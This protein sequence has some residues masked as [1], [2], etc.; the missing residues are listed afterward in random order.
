MEAHSLL[1]NGLLRLLRDFP[2]SLWVVDADLRVQLALGADLEA[3]GDLVG[4]TLE[5]VL[6]PLGESAISAHRAALEG[7]AGNFEVAFGGRRRRSRVEPLR[8]DDGRVEGVIGVSIDASGVHPSDRRLAEFGAVAVSSRDAIVGKTLDGVVTSWN[9]GAEATYGYTAEEMVG[10]SIAAVVPPDRLGELERILERAANGIA[11]ESLVTVRVRKDGTR[12]TVALTVS[13]T[14]GR[15]GSIV[16]VSAVGRDISGVLRTEVSLA[17]SEALMKDVIDNAFDAVVIADGDGRI[18]EFNPAA[19]AMFGH[20]RDDVVG[21]H[22]EDVLVPPALRQRHREGMAR[23]LAGGES[24][25]VGTRV[26]LPALRADGTELPVEIAITPIGDGREPFFVGFLR[27]VSMRRDLE[28]RLLQSQKMEAIGNLAAGIAHDF[29]NILVVIR[30]VSGLLLDEVD[31]A[32]RDH[33]RDIDVAATRAAELTRQL[34]AF[35]RQ[36][37]LSLE[38]VD[39]NLVVGESVALMQRV[40]ESNVVLTAA[41]CE[42]L[43]LVVG[44]RTNLQQVIVNLLINARDALPGAGRIQIRT[45]ETELDAEYAATN[46]DAAPGSY[47]LL[48]VTDDGVGMSRETQARVFEPYFTT[49]PSGTGL[50]LATV[51][52]IVKQI[53][54]HVAV[55]SE[56]GIGTTVRVYLPTVEQAAA[57]DP[58]GERPGLGGDETILVVEDNELVRRLV[59]RQLEK[60]GYSVVEAAGGEEAIELVRT[61]D[62]PVDL[63]LTD[64]VMGEMS[65]TDL[66]ERLRAEAGGIKVLYTSGYPEDVVTRREIAEDAP[67]IQ[68]PFR[69]DDLLR[70]I[71]RALDAEQG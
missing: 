7:H 50:G 45:G 18:V 10:R 16:G 64:L 36:Q 43:P 49:K 14:Y 63:V 20:A 26:E 29:N 8:G 41:V 62:T 61:R 65:G 35:G 4:R 30:G 40:L 60:G 21:R 52:G 58:A 13:P 69:P 12:I 24:R 46:P 47:V 11:T 27:D 3:A 33:V 6:G 70:G 17:R 71:R 54:G 28:R 39:L 53:G 32:A 68:K 51:Y 2:G 59:V 57:P 34:L 37:N 25:I 56:E 42:R 9:K 55:Y 5:Q 22:V 19:E 44:D 23:Y 1:E 67:F 66:A 38:P 31:G 15:D 48:E